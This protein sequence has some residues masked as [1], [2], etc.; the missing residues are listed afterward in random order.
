MVLPALTNSVTISDWGHVLKTKLLV[1]E[2]SVAGTVL[3]ILEII[4]N[5]CLQFSF[6]RLTAAPGP[7]LSYSGISLFQRLVKL[8]KIQAPRFQLVVS[9][10]LGG[11]PT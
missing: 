4:Q 10:P 1:D 8:V 2:M 11:Q 9:H 6:V 5:I 3:V 7:L